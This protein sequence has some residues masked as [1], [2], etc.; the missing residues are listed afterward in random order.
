MLLSNVDYSFFERYYRNDFSS[1]LS[2]CFQSYCAA[3]DNDIIFMGFHKDDIV[4]IDTIMASM[5]IDKL[6]FPSVEKMPYFIL[7]VMTIIIADITVYSKY[8]SLS[9]EWES[10]TRYP[11]FTGWNYYAVYPHYVF[12]MM[13]KAFPDDDIGGSVAKLIES[14]GEKVIDEISNDI[15]SILKMDDK[16]LIPIK[17]FVGSWF[18]YE[19]IV[20]Q[21]AKKGMDYN[22]RCFLY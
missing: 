21:A 19:T 8:H 22:P 2:R 15:V 9:K 10:M 4:H 20:D 16:E 12:S 11:K 6:V 18:T 5:S 17:E 14:F 7:S 1:D 3:T 13:T